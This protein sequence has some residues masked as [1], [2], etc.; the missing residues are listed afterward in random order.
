MRTPLPLRDALARTVVIRHESES[1]PSILLIRRSTLLSV[2]AI[3][4]RR[5]QDLGHDRVGPDPVRPQNEGTVV[6]PQEGRGEPANIRTGDLYH[7]RLATGLAQVVVGM[8]D[9]GPSVPA[10]LI[11]P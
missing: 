3:V 9:G 1:A 8:V 4:G 7:V 11:P 10:L 5:R 6:H 2:V